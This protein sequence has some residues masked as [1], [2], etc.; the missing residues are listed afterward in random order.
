MPRQR[1]MGLIW[2]GLDRK[3][4]FA[5]CVPKPVI[6]CLQRSWHLGCTKHRQSVGPDPGL[7]QRQLEWL[8]WHTRTDR[9]VHHAISIHI[10]DEMQGDMPVCWRVLD[11]PKG[12]DPLMSMCEQLL[13]N[14][15]IRPK[16]QKK[17]LGSCGKWLAM[18]FG[19]E[20]STVPDCYA[21]AFIRSLVSSNGKRVDYGSCPFG[22]VMSLQ[23]V[24]PFRA[25]GARF[26]HQAFGHSRDL[27]NSRIKLGH[28][29]P[30]VQK[31]PRD[32]RPAC[33]NDDEVAR[34]FS[35][36]R[37]FVLFQSFYTKCLTHIFMVLRI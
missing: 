11:R 14:S 31:K 26:R 33:F 27:L 2:S 4:E 3:G 32:H 16:R 19:A 25:K 18:H 36:W 29:F 22:G 12:P 15:I 23:R 34:R 1:D 7:I 13:L 21:H 6:E 5:Q 30:C 9:N 37:G 17:A 35:V 20:L 24:I 28:H 8:K 10:T